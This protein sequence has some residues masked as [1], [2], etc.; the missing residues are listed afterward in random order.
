MPYAR[1]AVQ[2]VYFLQNV[3]IK[4][5]STNR[6]LGIIFDDKLTFR[7]QIENIAVKMK[8]ETDGRIE[9]PFHHFEYI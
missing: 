2:T 7:A 4:K 8:N 9:L 1:M 5:V 3:E 6:V